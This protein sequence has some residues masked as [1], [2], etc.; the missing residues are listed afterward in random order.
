[1]EKLKHNYTFYIGVDRYDDKPV[2]NDLS[3]SEE[4]VCYCNNEDQARRIFQ[5]LC[6]EQKRKANESTHDRRYY[7][8]FTINGTTAMQKNYYSQ[9][10][11]DYNEYFCGITGKY[12]MCYHNCD[13]C[14]L[15]KELE[16]D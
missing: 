3:I 14:K 9:K 1:M 2:S 5:I 6:G 4:E 12:V 16:N 7:V 10:H 11:L 13:T 15:S 8:Y